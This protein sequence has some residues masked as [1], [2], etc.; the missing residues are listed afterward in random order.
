M[1]LALASLRHP[2]RSTVDTRFPVCASSAI[3][4]DLA[5]EPIPP[6]VARAGEGVDLVDARAPPRT[7]LA[8]ALVDVGLTVGT[9]VASIAL[10]SVLVD[11]IDALPPG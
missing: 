9:G 1:A 2:F 7:I 5:R 8:G 4:G 10:A 11:S 3:S 6:H